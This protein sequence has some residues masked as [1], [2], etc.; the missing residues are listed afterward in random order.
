VTEGLLKLGY[1]PG[2]VWV[3]SNKANSMKLNATP[4]ELRQFS[5]FFL[6]FGQEV[7]T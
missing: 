1:I 3:I 4:E 7:V 6:N 5:Q 2:N